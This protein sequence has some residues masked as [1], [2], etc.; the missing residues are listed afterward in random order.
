M[1]IAILNL[2]PRKLK[3]VESAA[4]V[5]AADNTQNNTAKVLVPPPNSQLGDRITLQV[6][7]SLLHGLEILL[8]FH[9]G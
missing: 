7:T 8:K 1:I 5:L 6:F 2:K 9:R 3:G 4:M